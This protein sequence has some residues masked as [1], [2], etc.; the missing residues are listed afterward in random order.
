MKIITVSGAHSGVGKTTIAEYMLS[1]LKGWSALKVTVSKD[2]RCPRKKS[3]GVCAEIKEPFHI[4]TDEGIINQ[5]G[6]DTARLKAA[7]ARQV[8]WLKARSEGLREG[9]LEALLDFNDCQGV[10]IEGT[11]VL[12]FIKPVLNIH[13]YKRGKVCV[14]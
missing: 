7:G 5:P 4:V 13:I 1:R 3:C 9:L 14:R 12:K 11:S 8:I 10:I 2:G 6:K